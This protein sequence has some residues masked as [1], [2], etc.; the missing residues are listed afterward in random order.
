MHYNY[1]MNLNELRG[2]PILL[3]GKS[4][5][6]SHDEFLMQLKAHG[7]TLAES[8]DEGIALIV[9]GRMMNPLE[10]QMRDELYGKRTAPFCDIDTL[11]KEL[12]ASIDAAKLTM[13]LKLSGDRERLLGYLQNPYIGDTLFLKLIGMYD[14]GGEGFFEND[15]NRDVTAA[16]IVRFYDHIERNHNVQYANTGLMHLLAQR[17][18]PELINTI[19]GLEPLQRALREGCD[20]STRKILE[21]LASHPAAER[22]VL[23]RMA[24]QGDIALKVRIAL[25]DDLSADLQQ[26]LFTLK[27]PEVHEALAQNPVLEHRIA[28]Q[29]EPAYGDTIASHIA[30]DE[31]LFE[32]YYEQ[33]PGA[34]ALNPTLTLA[35]QRRVYCLDDAVQAALASNPKAEE[36]MLMLL[37]ET[38]K[39]GVLASLAANPATPPEVLGKMGWNRKIHAAL[40][41][42]PS[43]P[44]ELLETLA[45]SEA[46]EVLTA[47]AKNRSTPAGL[48]YQLQL[49]KRLERYV[50]ENPGFGEHIQR[51]N[52][53]WL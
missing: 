15:A 52:I 50:M 13:S 23:A 53:G 28:V 38:N 34:V 37:Y 30:L 46:V 35:M 5:A 7:I 17:S 41:S 16:L 29:M 26:K 42:N 33:R 39:P 12:C 19:A 32:R 49:D 21:A 36:Q 45:A 47:L 1:S 24:E 8:G 18:D 44:A 22:S 11:E 20:P 4:R 25:R 48:L 3:L 43:S 10:Q 40:A 6:L 31:P 9:E 2:Q 27:E 51:E 14:W